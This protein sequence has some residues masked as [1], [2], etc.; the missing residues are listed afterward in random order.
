M[1][2][3]RV[4]DPELLRLL[5]AP[6][7]PAGGPQRVTDPDLI[8]QLEAPD[9]AKD[10]GP[11]VVADVAKAIP[12]GLARGVAGVIGLPHAAMKLADD[13]FFTPAAKAIVRATGRTPTSDLP[14]GDPRGTVADAFPSQEQVL[15]PVEAVTGEL[16][17]PKTLPGEVANALAEFAPNALF[18]GGSVV[19]RLGQVVVPALASEG[20]GQAARRIMPAAEPAARAVGALGGAVG[21]AVAQA[22]KA[23]SVLMRQAL[24]GISPEDL[25]AA[26]AL[27]EQ[28]KTLPGGGV[29]L[30]LD[31][32]LNHVTG[33]RATRLSQVSRVVANSG[34]EGARVLNETYAARPVQVD[35]V[36]RAALDPI[37]PE[38]AAP[39]GVGLDVQAA[40][41]AGVAQ[42]PEG[43]ALTAAREA[44]GPRTTADQAGRVIQP[45]MRGVMDAREATRAE[46]AN[47]DYAAARSAPENVGIERMV[48]VERPGE[49][50]VT[51]A[52][53]SRPQFT[54]AAPRPLDPPPTVEAEATAGP[55]SLARFIARN[56]GIRLD[57]EAAATDLHRFN[58]PGLGNVARLDGKSIDN[59]WRERLMEE[60]YFRPD[61]DGGMARDISS[62]LL[63]KL[64]NEQRGFPSYPI[65]QERVAQAG[66]NKPGQVQDDY[67]AALSEA[68]SR[69]DRDLVG[70]GVDPGTIH[71][72]LRE[73]VLG[74]LMRGEESDPLSAY[75][76]TVNAMREPPAPFVKST[77]V[78]EQIPDVQFGQVDPRPAAEALTDQA[79]TAKGDIRGALAS[80]GRDLRDPSG[81]LDMTVEGLRN[82]RGRLDAGIQ[83]AAAVG[84]REKAAVLQ[85]QRAALDEQLKAVPELARA[86]ANFAANSRPLEPFQGNAPLAQI[87][88]REGNMPSGR[89]VTPAEQVPSALSGPTAAREFLANAT[90]EARQAFEGHVAT[91]LLDG[92]TDRHGNIDAAKLS[93]TLRDNADVLEQMPAVYHRLDDVVRARDGL[94]RVEASPL[95]QL[96]EQGDVGRAINVLFP[97]APTGAGHEEV[98]TAMRAVARNNPGAARDLARI[99]LETAL[100]AGTRDLR[101]MPAQY[102]GA[103]FASGVRGN[104]QQA[105]NLEA[106]I[107]ALPQGD[108]IWRG[109]DRMLD[110]L[111]ATGWRP[112][113]GSDTAFNIDLRKQMA[114]TK[115]PLAAAISDAAT[116]AAV[117]G[118]AGGAGGAGGAALFGLKNAAKEAHLRHRIEVNGEQLARMLTDPAALPDLRALLRS[119]EGTPNAQLFATRLLTLA[120]SGAKSGH[121]QD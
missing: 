42:S 117:G 4:T 23:S 78:E 16:P 109:L 9:A 83:A 106:S 65:G 101:G 82:A 91:R 41:R 121:R 94:A 13:V 8:R 20:L 7:A 113:K 81:E 49:P 80:Y 67:R 11:S 116:H 46:Q 69:L 48:T 90:P 47:R 6:E 40:A 51:P 1:A 119:R 25:A 107:R 97:R 35:R 89:F 74:A 3:A 45:Q 71:P 33:G 36:G 2:G 22:P 92:A 37:A 34:G 112:Q 31:E 68:E 70:A 76:R 79:R 15:R 55:M 100:N 66:R 38:N 105:K 29:D 73:R 102:G 114:E 57:G 64:Q 62:E 99:H 118:L 5:D 111:E 87:T 98:A 110:T 50:V 54:D 32:A 104:P 96:A 26:Q 95:G 86:D 58:I 17:K 43:M 52:Q 39:S 27:R 56:G 59:F 44:V 12:S 10:A 108:T 30:T 19:Q 88:R 120:H 21:A 61:A 115:G 28:A 24:D 60:G 77:T 93:E 85:A 53:Y 103:S 18:G 14:G 72:D 63:R 84:D 75:E